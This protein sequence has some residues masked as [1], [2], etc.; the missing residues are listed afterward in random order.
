MIRWNEE[1]DRWLV[2]TRGVSF[3]EI[4][5]QDTG[6]RL[7]RPI[8]KSGSTWPGHRG[9]ANQGIYW[10]V[11]FVVEDDDALFLKTAYPSR[12]FHKRHG[13]RNATEERA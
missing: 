9:H 3:H 7:H 8:G 13:G 4:A 6:Q 1:K 5:D 10:V 12:R 2:Q 11:P